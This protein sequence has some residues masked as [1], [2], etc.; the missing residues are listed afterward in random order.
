[1]SKYGEVLAL[2]DYGRKLG[3]EVADKDKKPQQTKKEKEPD[4]F[5]LVAK[6]RK[7]LAQL[8]AVASDLGKLYKKEEKKE[9][10]KGW[11]ERN[12]ALFLIASSPVLGPFYVW[13]FR[14]MMGI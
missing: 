13:W 9:D 10:K 4:I 2:L 8:E 14:L 12:I 7:E 3:Q 6:K 11:S 1:M 5:E